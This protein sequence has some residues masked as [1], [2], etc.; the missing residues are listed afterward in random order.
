M[1]TIE[2]EKPFQK[3]NSNRISYIGACIIGLSVV[4]IA[5]GLIGWAAIEPKLLPGFNGNFIIQL[6]LEYVVLGALII[7]LSWIFRYGAYLQQEYDETV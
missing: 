4:N 7:F 1:K 2:S 3:E 6:H 5:Y